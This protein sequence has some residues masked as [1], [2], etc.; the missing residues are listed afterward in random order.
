MHDDRGILATRRGRDVPCYHSYPRAVDHNFT[1]WSFI[2][3]AC[4]PV[5][6][7]VRP[8]RIWRLARVSG[9][10]FWHQCRSRLDP[11]APV[12][13][14]LAG[15]WKCSKPCWSMEGGWLC[16]PPAG[17]CGCP[18]RVP[19]RAAGAA[20]VLPEVSAHPTITSVSWRWLFSDATEWRTV[21]ENH[22]HG[23]GTAW[24]RLRSP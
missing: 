15:V 4:A 11:P 2:C 10:T 12:C 8:K 5:W 17:E 7:P 14:G 1:W 22:E 13:F 21:C 18:M 9:S 20:S 24:A 19:P 16:A 6:K 23:Q 3:S